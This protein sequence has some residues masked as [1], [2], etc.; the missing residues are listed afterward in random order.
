VKEI[1]ND[2]RIS[3]NFNKSKTTLGIPH[4]NQA[5]DSLVLRSVHVVIILGINSL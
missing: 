4:F 5:F 3:T 1:I 2:I